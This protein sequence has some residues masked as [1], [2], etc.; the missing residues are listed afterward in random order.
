MGPL[1]EI[2]V[3]LAELT[4]ES[5]EDL[6]GWLHVRCQ[7]VPKTDEILQVVQVVQTLGFLDH[8][9]SQQLQVDGVLL[10]PSALICG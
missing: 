4:L 8:L 1:M 5:L 6:E 7:P 2:V 9:M 3:P 10:H